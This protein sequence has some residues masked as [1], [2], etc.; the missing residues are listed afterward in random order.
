VVEVDLGGRGAMTSRIGHIYQQT[1]CCSR[2]RIAQ[3][4]GVWSA[5]PP[6][7]A[8]ANRAPTTTSIG[9]QFAADSLCLSSF[10]FFWRAPQNYFNFARVTSRPL[11]SFKVI[12]FGA[13]Q[14]RVCDFLLVRHSNLSCTFRR[15]CAF[16]CAPDPPVFHSN[17]GG[18]PNPVAPDHP[19]WA[20]TSAW[21]FKLFGREIIFEE[22][23]P[24]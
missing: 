16:F 1:S 2:Q 13:N 11:R 17:F 18:V 10:K 24:M 4:G 19:C 20:S 21:T 23:Q 7:F 3:V 15:F 12:E 8:P 6:M 22:F 5:V 14:K 9:L